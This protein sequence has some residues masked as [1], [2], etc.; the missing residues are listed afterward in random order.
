MTGHVTIVRLEMQVIIY[1]MQICWMNGKKTKAS[2]REPKEA[3][4][5]FRWKHRPPGMSQTAGHDSGN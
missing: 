2:K 3:K 1:K 4:S 5:M